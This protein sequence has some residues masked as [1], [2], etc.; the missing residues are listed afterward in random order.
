[1]LRELITPMT[2][3]FH[4]TIPNEYIGRQVEFIMFALDEE[5]PFLTNNQN[6]ETLGGSLNKYAD[7]SKIELEQNA[8]ELH[9][10][11]KYK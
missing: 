4:I 10:S 11:D 7:L 3:D 6:I 9:V 2:N 8:W 5:R 1:M